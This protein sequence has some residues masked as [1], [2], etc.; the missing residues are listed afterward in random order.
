MTVKSGFIKYV[1]LTL[2]AV[3]TA[4]PVRSQEIRGTEFIHLRQLPHTS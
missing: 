4:L 1:L 2:L 3:M